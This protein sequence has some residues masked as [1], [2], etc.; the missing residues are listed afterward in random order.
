MK[1]RQQKGKEQHRQHEGN[2]KTSVYLRGGGGGA[3]GGPPA[4]GQR[5][6]QRTP[7]GVPRA[8]HAA[9]RRQSPS[10]W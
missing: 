4:A 8:V 2:I 7:E 5:R 6:Q 10:L 3:V 9:A 1:H